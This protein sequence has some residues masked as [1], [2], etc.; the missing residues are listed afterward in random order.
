MG[1]RKER[2]WMDNELYKLELIFRNIYRKMKEQFNSR[3]NEYVTTNEY[4]VL[5]LMYNGKMRVTDLSKTLEVSASHITSI[6]DS[7]VQKNLIERS[8]SSKDRR[9]V[10]LE[11]TT[12][13]RALIKNL[14]QITSNY[15]QEMF[16]VFTDDEKKEL[17][18]LLHKLEK[19]LF[20][21]TKE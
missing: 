15:M 2:K 3:M 13:G 5:K 11:L 1:K 21:E 19:Q 12:E 6:T 14:N 10:D 18:T 9:V 20:N 8:R 16:G 17:I 4:M 7:L